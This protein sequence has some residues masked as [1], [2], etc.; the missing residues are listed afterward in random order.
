MNAL[1]NV[2]RLCVAQRKAERSGNGGA[3]VSPAQAMIS[4]DIPYCIQKEM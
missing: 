3:G 1:E 2:R 4:T